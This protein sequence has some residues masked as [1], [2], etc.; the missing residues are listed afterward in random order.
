M[1]ALPFAYP[2][3]QSFIDAVCAARAVKQIEHDKFAGNGFTAAAQ[4]QS[5]PVVWPIKGVRVDGDKVIV[6]VKGG[7]DAARWL[8]AELISMLASPQGSTPK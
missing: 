5:K 7:N 6:A 8:C 3:P 4:E 2:G 1:S